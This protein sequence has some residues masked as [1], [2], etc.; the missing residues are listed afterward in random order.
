MARVYMFRII[1]KIN[2]VSLN[3]KGRLVFNVDDVLWEVR[4]EIV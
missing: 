2:T 4:T 3:I 1:L